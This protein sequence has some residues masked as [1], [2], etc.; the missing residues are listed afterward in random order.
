MS[1]VVTFPDML[2]TAA[3]EVDGI[4]SAINAANATAAG[5]T[6]GLLAAAEDEVSAAIAKLFGAFGQDYQAAVR[7]AAAF[8]N[9][10]T[11]ALAAAAGAYAQAEA[12][13]AAF[14]SGV[15]HALGSATSPFQSLLT[16]TGT[17]GSAALSVT[18]AAAATQIALIMGG[19]GNPDPDPLYL[20]L[21]NNNYIQQ[22]FPGA[23]PTAMPTPEQ[24]WPVTPQLGNLTFNQSVTQGVTALHNAINTQLAA[25]NQ[26]IALGYSQSATIVNNEI[27]ALIAAGSPNAGDISFVTIGN[28]NTPEGGLLSRF[29]GFY[30]PFLDVPFNGATPPDAPYA[31][32]IYTAQYDGIA[33]APRYPLHI[34]SD[35]NAIMGYF[36]VHNT[37]PTLTPDQIA[38]AVPLPTSP[39]YTGNTQY[40]MLL[41]QDLPLVQPIRDIPYAGPPLADLIQP[42]LR[43]LVD[44]GY[45]DYGPG[46][47]YA[48]IPT[49]AGFFSIPNPFAVSYYLALGSL[50]APYGAAVEIG[51]EAGLWGPEWFPDVYPWVPSV[52]PGLNLYLGQPSVTLLSLLSGGLGDILHLI[53]PPVF[54]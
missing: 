8:H 32:T 13:N 50:Q 52:N 15:S 1:Y 31:H 54:P 2:A 23:I 17:A 35:I 24:F 47:N 22:L 20:D 16:P 42:Q 37:Y 28:P 34:L 3:T 21:I 7:Q 30:I 40:Y 25:G 48:D 6:T 49:P 44:L 33:N 29:P 14:V 12:A 26:V 19:T 4:A 45:A 27:N 5:P 11:K 9:E 51:V 18:P 36:Y 10:F 46:L 41:T 38:N 53:P 43:V 39:G